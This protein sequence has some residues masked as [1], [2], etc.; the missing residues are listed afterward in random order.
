MYSRAEIS[1]VTLRAQNVVFT[2]ERYVITG[3]TVNGMNSLDD[4]DFY[5]LL[6]LLKVIFACSFARMT[7]L[8]EFL[9]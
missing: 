3:D 2:Y 8:V 7:L 4:F 6:L 5:K 1:G 9:S